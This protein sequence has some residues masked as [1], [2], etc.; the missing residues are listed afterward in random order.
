MADSEKNIIDEIA[1][2]ILQVRQIPGSEGIC[3]QY[4]SRYDFG[5]DTIY[6]LL[7]PTANCP[8]CESFASGWGDMI[9]RYA[10]DAATVLISAYSD[11]LAAQ[12]YNAKWGLD[13]DHYIYDTNG[14]YSGF[15]SFDMGY[16]HI[17]YILKIIPATGELIVGVEAESNSDEFASC[18]VSYT[19]PKEKLQHSRIADFTPIYAFGRNKALKMHKEFKISTPDSIVLSEIDNNPAFNGNKFAFTDKL[20]MLTEIFR[21]NSQCNTLSFDREISCNDDEKRTFIKVSEPEYKAFKNELRYMPLSPM[22]TNDSTMYISYSLP[23]LTYEG[24]AAICYMNQS[25]LLGINTN[26]GSH[27]GVSSINVKYDDGYFI[28]H[29]TQYPYFGMIAMP[30]QRRT[31]PMSYDREE[32]ENEAIRNPFNEAFYTYKQPLFAIIDPT[33]GDI[34]QYAGNLPDISRATRTG[35]AFVSPTLDTYGE[36]GVMADGV[37]GE[38]KYIN[39]A[40][41]DSVLR[42]YR[43]F[44]IDMNLITEPDTALFYTYD[45]TVPYDNVL[46]R[47]VT[48]VKISPRKIHCIVRYGKHGDENVETDGYC[49]VEIDRKSGKRKER[50]FP[51]ANVDAPLA[52]SLW[53]D[54]NG[55]VNPYA[56]YRTAQGWVLRT[57]HI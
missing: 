25:T 30:C 11:S 48:T 28:A 19:T 8:R 29:F 46:C 34:K 45:C 4:F 39:K 12:A 32:Y 54:E 36:D 38:L 17:P 44:D 16:L 1:D 15:L 26:T 2:D 5:Q 56:V 57:F 14:G 13:A 49:Y 6:A 9:K 31:W 24:P 47:H 20:R 7:N 53:R 50:A 35:A 27:E 43:A 42:V 51:A 22:W 55:N 41:G 40:T 33:T 23:S 18:L 21:V 37:S 10:P 52:Y 3:R